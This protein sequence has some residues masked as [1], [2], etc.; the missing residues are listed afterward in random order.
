M[1]KG[2]LIILL[3]FIVIM[4]ILFM[5]FLEIRKYNQEI[6]KFN[7]SYEFFNR[8]DLHG[9][10]ITTVINKAIDNNERFEV[11]KDENGYYLDDE[12]CIKIEVKMAING[13]TYDMER[14]VEIGLDN[15]TEFFGAINFCCTK[16]EYHNENGKVSKMIFEATEK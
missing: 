1:K 10:D 13:K 11:S 14:I 7:Y 8:N 6:K 4:I 12:N 9:L 3:I 5:K 2:F 16:I 15:F